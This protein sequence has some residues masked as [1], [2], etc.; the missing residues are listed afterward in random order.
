MPSWNDLLQEIEGLADDN[1]RSRLLVDRQLTALNEIGRLRGDRNVLFYAS[2][3]LQKPDIP[4]ILTMISPEDINGFM[5]TIYGMDWQ[6][7]LTLLL[8]T[9]GGV[10]NATETIVAYLRSKF[11]DIE[12][13]VPVYA[14]S[15]GAMI[16]LASNRIV[17]GRQ[18]QLGPIDPQMS[19][20]GRYVSARSIVDQFEMA[21]REIVADQNASLVWAPV[22]REIGPA[23]LQE[24]LNALHYSERMVGQWLERYMFAGQ[25]D[26]EAKGK[27]IAAYFN[28]AAHH[29]SHGHRIDR[30][31]AREQGV[32]VED[33]EDNQALQ[34]AVLTLYHMATIAFEKSPAAK[35]LAAHT[36]RMWVKNINMLPV[37]PSK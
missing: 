18:S 23:L 19:V 8:H 13:I 30:D 16:G 3:Y 35:L 17:M 25:T 36:G 2:S 10:T 33:L 21:K 32:V 12:V 22:L 5:A 20:D 9:P 27:R 7:G 24:V 15:A 1:Q 29:K 34:E 4:G 11:P 26:A 28:D 37:P 6:R 14:M 31:E